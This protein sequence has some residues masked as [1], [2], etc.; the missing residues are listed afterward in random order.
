MLLE[1]LE[2]HNFRNLQGVISCGQH[3]NIIFGENGQ[4]KTNWLEA[5]Y[6]LATTKSF[7]TAK[8]QDS[9]RFDEEMA[10]VRGSVQQSAEIR[11]TIQVTLQNNSKTLSINGK[12]ESVNRYLGQLYT[13]VFNADELE[14]VRGTP[15]HR[16]KFL[17]AGIVGI[18]PPFVQTLA[19][20][21]RVI[22]QKNALLQTAQENDYGLEKTAE[23]LEIWNE[24]LVLLA[25][26]I[27]KARLR[28]VERLQEVLEKKLFQREEI[29]IRYVSSLEGKGD[30]SDY[31]ALLT[32]RLK[33]RVQAE[34]AS[35]YALLGTHRDDL[36]IQFDGRDLRAF[37]SSGQQRSALLLLQI[38][39]LSV[40]FT[41]HNEYPLFLLDDIDAELDYK[42]IGQLLEFLSDKTQTF[43]TTS[44]ESF[45]EKFG[46]NATIFTV[47][48]GEPKTHEN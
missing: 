9:I 21:N 43:V 31:G 38:A 5:I 35:G 40:Y 25:T 13:V 1:S 42:R 46:A 20:Y 30:L 15:E 28:Y 12:K 24:Q 14:I 16:R 6:I 27:H 10:W 29:S 26:R 8:L 44:K 39:N 47:E 34:L 36:E 3:L 4:G 32:E 19:D 17:D 23:M 33:L 7:K 2:V 18:Y 11:R 22:K 37:G 45:V 48:K 41:Q